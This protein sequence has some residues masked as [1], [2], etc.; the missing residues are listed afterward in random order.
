MQ[1]IQ[2]VANETVIEDFEA[3]YES[4]VRAEIEQ[5]RGKSDEFLA[6]RI[7]DDQF[8]PLRLRYGVYGQRQPGVQMVRC[9]IPGGLATSEQLEQLASVADKY[10]DGSAHL[11]TRQNI[12]FHFVRLERVPEL[13]H[14]LADVRLTTR[15]ACFNTVRN[16]TACPLAG[17]SPDEVFDVRP[18]AQKVALAFLRQGL[19]DNLPRKFK[20]GFSGCAEDCIKT[21][22]NDIGLRAVVRS[23]NGSSKRGFRIV[24]GGGLGPMPV[25][26]RLLDEF[27]PEERLVNRIEAVIRVFNRDGNRGNKHKARLKFLILERGFEWLKEA[28]EDAY[29][30]I[31]KNGGI[32][33]PPAIP[34]GFGGFRRRPQITGRADL[35]PV[36]GIDR[37]PDPEFDRWLETNVME[38]KQPGYCAVTALV[39]QGN[40]ISGQMRSLARI[41]FDAG[42]G[43]L[44]LTLEQN[45]V[46]AYVPVWSLPRVY[47]L[48]RQIGLESSGARQ[49]KD[50][51]TCPGAYSCNLGLTKSMKLGAALQ[52]TVSGYTDP[53]VR[54]LSIKISGCPNSCGHHWIADLG[55]YGNARKIDGKE[56][57]YYQMLLG[58]GYDAQGMMHFGLAVQSIPAKLAPLAVSRVLDH[59]IRNRQPGENFRNYVFRHKVATFREMTNDLAKP[60]ELFPE[61]YQDWG[62]QEGFSL[63]LGRGECAA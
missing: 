52:E 24:I 63:K 27:L 47:S 4:T 43:L 3:Q 54:E 48:L 16:V 51:T 25:E 57:P 19:T 62:D 45:L 2:D 34:E 46:L 10:A 11:T 31:L 53:G 17:L 39:D 9:K 15:E 30:E 58:G 29:A 59:F 32:D 61:I 38:Q 55:F 5:F 6:G 49:I 20:I 50:I 44:R 23:E 13:M 56:V 21:A 41:A 18:Y 60:A 33:T 36:A 42:D 22:I 35:L 40:L 12:Q 1:I 26:A 8:R 28:I 7:S 14:E 37:G